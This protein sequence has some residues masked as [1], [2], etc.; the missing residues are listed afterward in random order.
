M[1][2]II[3]ELSQWI[4]FPINAN[5]K[6]MYPVYMA[7]WDISLRLTVTPVLGDLLP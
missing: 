1:C 6:Y 7:E 4:S 5:N 3:H 2:I